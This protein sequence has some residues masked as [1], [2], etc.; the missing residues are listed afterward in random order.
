MGGYDPHGPGTIMDL[1]RFDQGLTLAL[2]LLVLGGAWLFVQRHKQGLGARLNAGRR[3]TLRETLPLGGQTRA[4]LLQVDGRELLV[5]HGKG[6]CALHD[7]GGASPVKG[8]AQ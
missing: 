6:I 2:F 7:L 4:T 5:I 8:A 3:M 1:V